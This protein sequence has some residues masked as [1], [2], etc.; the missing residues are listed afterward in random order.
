MKFQWFQVDRIWDAGEARERR[1]PFE[2]DIS[3]LQDCAA[4]CQ[5]AAIEFMC[6]PFAPA[7]V[8]LLDP[9][10]VRW[11]VA[12]A[13]VWDKALLGAMYETKKPMLVSMGAVVPE[14]VVR[15]V[16]RIQSLKNDEARPV[17]PLHCVSRYPALPEEYGLRRWLARTGLHVWGLSDHSIGIGTAIAA[18]TLGAC[19]VEKHIA[20]D[21][22]PKS[23]DDGPYALRPP[24][25]RALI[26]GI[27]QAEAA[28][29]GEVA[30]AKFPDGRKVWR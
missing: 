7:Q 1:R 16:A 10:V 11:K 28:L 12:S 30:P 18:V 8:P 19:V 23:P 9:L 27:R 2:V 20:L 26:A 6:T 22:Q 14:S 21:E 29:G 5:K 15:A 25:L 4:Y 13:H 3:F 17:V 24:G